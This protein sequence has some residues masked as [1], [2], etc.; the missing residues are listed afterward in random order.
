MKTRLNIKLIFAVILLAT[1]AVTPLLSRDT[2]AQGMA[3]KTQGQNV[4]NYW[5]TP[6]HAPGPGHPGTQSLQVKYGNSGIPAV[7][8]QREDLSPEFVQ[9]IVRKGI[10]SMAP[11]R[12]TEISDNELAAIAAYL[13]QK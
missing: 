7:L 1:T 11:F 2:R 12:K 13:S 5:C 10:M 3:D 4:Y 9:T 8:E 6:C